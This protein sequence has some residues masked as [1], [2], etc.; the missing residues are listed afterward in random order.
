M[1]QAPVDGIM[2]QKWDEEF[3]VKV[4]NEEWINISKEMAKQLLD[5]RSPHSI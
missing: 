4:S 1:E 3:H 5:I 2:K